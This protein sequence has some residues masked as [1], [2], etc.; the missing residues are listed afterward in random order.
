MSAKCFIDEQSSAGM[1]FILWYYDRLLRD[2]FVVIFLW[3]V[4]LSLSLPAPLYI[5]CVG[6]WPLFQFHDIF[7]QTVGLLGRVISPSQGRYL[8]TGQ[9]KHRINAHTDIHASNGIRTHDPS[10]RASEDSSC[11]YA[12]R[13]LWSACDASSIRKDQIN[14]QQ[15][16][17]KPCNL[18]PDY[19]TDEGSLEMWLVV[20]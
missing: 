7:T 20:E 13:P 15:D 6:P 19:S 9:H 2:T 16:K 17:D 1:S 12:A 8:H 3:R 18:C 10:V 11:L 5:A 4:S 14:L